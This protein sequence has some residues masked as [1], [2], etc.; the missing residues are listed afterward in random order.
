[1]AQ[2]TNKFDFFRT[3]I[4]NNHSNTSIV[5]D[6]GEREIGEKE[7]ATQRI[8]EDEATRGKMGK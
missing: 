3:E 6:E 1:M 4:R 7:K 8:R 2:D 5:M